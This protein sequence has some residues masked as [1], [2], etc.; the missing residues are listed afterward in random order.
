MG[1]T[2]FQVKAL[3]KPG[4]LV[5]GEWKG[6]RF[7]AWGP[8]GWLENHHQVVVV[9]VCLLRQSRCVPCKSLCGFVGPTR[10]ITQIKEIKDFKL[11]LID[12]N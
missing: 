7:M 9:V 12:L 1:P 2:G 3:V 11:E 10:K 8:L 4:T 6:A 5:G